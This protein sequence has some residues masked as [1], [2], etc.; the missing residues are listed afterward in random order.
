MRRKKTLRTVRNGRRS[1]EGS[2][3]I[4][5]YGNQFV[6]RA[7]TG[8]GQRR[9]TRRI[10]AYMRMLGLR[11]V[12]AFKNGRAGVLVATRGAWKFIRE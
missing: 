2:D 9:S 7:L 3:V 4:S 11:R 10:A 6:S 5:L 1:G 12:A 8:D